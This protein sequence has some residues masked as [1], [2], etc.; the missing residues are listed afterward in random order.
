MASDWISYD[1]AAESHDR[2]AVP[3]FFE[4]PARDLIARTGLGSAARILDIGTGSGVAALRAA[5]GAQPHALVVGI[6]PSIEM[7]R[8]ARQKGLRVAAAAV[9]PGLPFANRSFDRVLA[10]FVLSHIRSY[11]AG[12]LDITRVLMPAGMLGVTTWGSME[13]DYRTFWQS[14]AESFI[15]KQMLANA[16][17]EALPWEDWFTE[18]GHVADAL[19]AAGLQDVD[20][21]PVLYTIHTNIDDFLAIRE[22][23]LQA[24]FIRHKLAASEW[25]RFKETVAAEFHRRFKDPIDHKRDVLIATGKRL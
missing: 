1:A 19:R 21:Q 16:M 5:E 23:S 9:T 8:V 6:D 20:V 12:L 2:L 11:E 18:P 3:S 24:R 14:L 22:S 15:D 4:R 25:E 10:S 13:N 7:L 17:R